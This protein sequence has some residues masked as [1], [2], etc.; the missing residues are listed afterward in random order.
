MSAVTYDIC[1]VCGSYQ[2]PNCPEPSFYL[3]SSSAI[4]PS[5][6]LVA[7][8]FFFLTVSWPDTSSFTCTDERINI[9]SLYKLVENWSI[10]NFSILNSLFLVPFIVVK[11]QIL[12][13]ARCI[14]A[15]LRKLSLG[16][17]SATR[18]FQYSLSQNIR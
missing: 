14:T 17:V 11:L 13:S 6:F 4:S 12:R 9:A 18:S 2:C 1:E 8:V 15:T 7:T 5:I 3:S 10:I 16:L